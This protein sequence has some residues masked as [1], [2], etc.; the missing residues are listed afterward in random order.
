MMANP[1]DPTPD[2]IPTAKGDLVKTPLAHLIVFIADKKLQGSLVLHGDD[3]STS[4]VYFASGAPAKVRTSYPG[5]HLGRVLLQLGYIDDDLLD[6][7]IV[8]MQQTGTLHGQLLRSMGAIDEAQLVAG[9]RE[10]MM[11]RILKIFEKV[12]DV[13]T[14]AFYGDV[15]L[16]DDYGGPEVTPIDPYRVVW[17]GMHLRPNDSSIDPTLARLGAAPIGINNQADFRRF[18]FGPPEGKVIE[19]LAVR[20]MSVVQ[21]LDL[22]VMPVRQIKLLVYVLLITKGIVVMPVQTSAPA[23]KPQASD[24]SISAQTPDSNR[25]GSDPGPV[26]T[27]QGVPMARVKLKKAAVASTTQ[28]TPPSG[29]TREEILER[30]KQIEGENLFQALGVEKDA[31]ADVVRSAYFALAKQWHPDRLPESHADV[32]DAA[33]KVFARMS[34]AFQTLSD[35]DK[36]AQYL[37]ALAKGTTESDEQAKV[38]Q[39]IEATIEYQKAEVYLRKHDLGKAFKSAQKAYEGDPEQA[40]HV[41]LYAWILAQQPDAQEAKNFEP[42][43]TLLDQAI[44]LNPRCEQAFL[45]RA[46][47]CKQMGKASVALRDFK[48]V[49][50]LNP[51]NIEANRE[52]RL[53]TMRGGVKDVVEEKPAAPARPGAKPGAK[54][55]ASQDINWTKDSV[56]DIFGKLFKKK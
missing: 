45:Y 22:S 14:Y 48:T 18:G 49:V 34:D 56:G 47:L 2:M 20:P 37:E 42:S 43:M 7:T 4:T 52:V 36:R 11:R 26:S 24:P 39:V 29:P 15:N 31:T 30:A 44:K 27:R 25:S 3:G 35:P 28:A 6:A 40:H 1:M 53:A 17:E 32:R 41:A 12:G 9:L 8:E 13:T 54:S 46:M 51:R 23:R 38:Q 33:A 10:Q 16:L 55:A 50:E 19:L 5:T 21:V